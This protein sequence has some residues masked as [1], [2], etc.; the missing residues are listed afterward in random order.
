MTD[1]TAV[2][3]V[4]R[5]WRITSY[6]P[7]V[8]EERVDYYAGRSEEKML[9]FAQECCDENIMEWN[10]ASIYEAYDM[11]EDEYLGGSGFIVEEISYE[12]FR[13]ESGY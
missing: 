13:E 4:K 1:T 10:D 8:G 3:S 7:F 2:S 11:N 12:E 9:E 5:F 6:T